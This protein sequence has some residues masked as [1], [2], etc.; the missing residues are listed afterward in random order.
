MIDRIQLT[1]ALAVCATPPCPLGEGPPHD[2]AWANRMRQHFAM[3]DHS[4]DRTELAMFLRIMEKEFQ[5]A[6][7][8]KGKW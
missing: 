2:K 1:E 3:G 4:G 8:G 7:G 6:M 5:R